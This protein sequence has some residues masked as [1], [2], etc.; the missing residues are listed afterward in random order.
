VFVIR[1]LLAQRHFAVLL[2]AATLLLKLIVPTGYMIGN[3]HGRVAIVVCSGIFTATGMAGPAMHG[4]MTDHGKSDDHGKMEQPCAFAGLS[5][6]ALGTI[7]PILL[8]A[9]IAFVLALGTAPMVP[10]PGIRRTAL[11]PPLRGPP[12]TL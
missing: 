6:A 5:A 11:P 12:V 9:L 10:L 2:C 7:D 1:H 3:E 8:T 4:A